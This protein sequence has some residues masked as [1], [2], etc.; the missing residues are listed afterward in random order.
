MAV[1]DEPASFGLEIEK[2]VVAKGNHLLQYT[3]SIQMSS[4]FTVPLLVLFNTSNF[5][6]R[7]NVA[8]YECLLTIKIS[9]SL[10]EISLKPGEKTRSFLFFQAIF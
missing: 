7:K 9:S 3:S 5:Y 4:Q 8:F 6:A 10:M 1:K 2:S